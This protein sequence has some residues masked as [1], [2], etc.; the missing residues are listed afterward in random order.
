MYLRRRKP[1]AAIPARRL[2]VAGCVLGLSMAL[3][4]CW[5]QATGAPA[6]PAWARDFPAPSGYPVAAILQPLP[7]GAVL[8]RNGSG[9]SALDARGRTLWSMPNV[10]DALLDGSMLVFWRPSVVFAVRARDAGVLWKRP[11]DRPPYVVAAGARLVTFCGDIS[12]VLR[13]RDGTILATRRPTIRMSPPHLDGARP[14]N[15]DYVLVSNFFDGAW[16]GRDYY[17]VDA[18][19]GAFLW[20]ETDCD[21]IDVTATTVSITPVPSMLPWGSTG[22]LERRRLADGKLT[23]ARTYA[24]PHAD[25]VAGGGRLAFSHAAAYVT[26]YGGVYRFVRGNVSQLQRVLDRS[27]AGLVAL[28]SA[29]FIAVDAGRSRYGT[30]TLYIDRP[31]SRGSFVTIPLGTYGAGLALR[32]LESKELLD[33]PAVR[34]GDSVAV[35][36]GRVIRLYDE[37]GKVELTAK[38]TCDKVEPAATRDVLFALCT[39][40]GMPMTLA[41]FRR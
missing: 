36:D 28:G 11:C 15:A 26:T 7:G 14:L 8:V 20:D 25:D 30:G 17:V 37:S 29:G 9:A 41:A 16:M 33:A 4:P 6:D 10:D 21:V 34:I 2:S 18:H 23:S 1:V 39:Q 38:V 31:A 5:A 24:A 35:A 19:T 22:L 40:Q 27:A 32:P 12:T 13:A 3:L